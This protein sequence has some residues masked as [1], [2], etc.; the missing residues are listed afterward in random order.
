M[1]KLT[2]FLNIFRSGG[3]AVSGVLI[4]IAVQIAEFFLKRFSWRVAVTF[5]VLGLL[6]TTTTTFFGVLH[7][8]LSGIAAAI[9]PYF[10]E[11]ANLILPSNTLPCLAVFFGA[12]VTRYLHDWLMGAITR[13]DDAIQR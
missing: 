2:S 7:T 4:Y 8:A 12:R 10:Q 3:A 9:P 1:F 5:L 11:G 13:I 6:A